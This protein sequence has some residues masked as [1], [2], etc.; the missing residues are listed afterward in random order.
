MQREWQMTSGYAVDFESAITVI[1]AIPPS[2]EP[3]DGG[4]RSQ[5]TQYPEIAVRE[6]V[7]NALIHQ[8]LRI[9]GS[10]PL[11]EIFDGRIDISNPGASLV[12]T[13][14]LVDNPPKSRNQEMASLMRRFHICE[15][16]GSGW[17]KTI[18][19]CEEYALPTP[20][21]INYTSNEGSMKVSLYP[22]E[23]YASMSS[24]ARVMACY[25]HACMCLIEDSPMGNSS[26][27]ARFGKDAPSS[28]TISRLI[29]EALDR[30]L[31][32]PVDP[33]ASQRYMRYVPFWA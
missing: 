5:E 6:I 31:I 32:K 30:E 24:E 3:I 22:Y 4:I 11:V 26:L 20:S 14:R 13:L 8:D 7:A 18:D 29:R 17:D 23:P 9:T 2:D 16:A 28:S 10:G 33:A 1:M 15:E 25:W 21:V 12:D 19:A 27:R